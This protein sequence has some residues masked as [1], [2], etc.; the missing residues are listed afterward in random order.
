MFILSSPL[1][2]GTGDDRAD[3]EGHRSLNVATA[4]PVPCNRH[5][6]IQKNG[7]GTL[8]KILLNVRLAQ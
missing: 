2:Y 1:I 6:P 8:K 4:R 7:R 5:F 3:G